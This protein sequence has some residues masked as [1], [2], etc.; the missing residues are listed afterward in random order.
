MRVWRNMLKGAKKTSAI[1][2]NGSLTETLTA[3]FVAEAN[4][5]LVGFVSVHADWWDRR[6]QRRTAEIHELV[7]RKDWQSKGVGRALM[8]AAL[9]YAR[10]QGC[11]YASLWVGEGTEQGVGRRCGCDG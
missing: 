2:W 6:Y 4:G 9:D 1:T 8:M 10:A 7:V 11:E 3:F 5:E